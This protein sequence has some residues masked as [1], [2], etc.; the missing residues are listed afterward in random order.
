MWCLMVF[1]TSF[2]DHYLASNQTKYVVL[3]IPFYGPMCFSLPSEF[4]K[5][6]MYE[7]FYI[8]VSRAYGFCRV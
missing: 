4:D 1:V 3:L 6:R 2:T 5:D 7:L 8:K